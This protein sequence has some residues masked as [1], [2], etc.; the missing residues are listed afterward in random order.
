M[1]DISAL[2]ANAAQTN[3]DFDLGK[4]NKSYWE[5][6]DQAAK[7]N[8]RDTLRNMPVG[9]NGELDYPAM[10][11][12]LV[13]GGDVANGVGFANLAA[14]QQE[15]RDYFNS[16]PPSTARGAITPDIAPR[17]QPGGE[18]NPQGGGRGPVATGP[19]SIAGIVGGLTP[20]PDLQGKIITQVASQARLDPNAAIDD[21]ATL[22]RITQVSQAAV[23][24]F[25]GQQPPQPQVAQPQP[26]VA[27]AQPQPQSEP[28]PLPPM[29]QMSPEDQQAAKR[30]AYFSGSPDKAVAETARVKLKAILDKYAPTNE[31]KNARASGETVPVYQQRAVDQAI[32][33]AGGVERAKQEVAEQGEYKTE[34]KAASNKLQVLNTMRAIIDADKN[35]DLGF[36]ADTSLK[37]QKV[38]QRLGITSLFGKN[39]TDLS[40]PELLQKLGT[41]LASESTKAISAR[42]AVFEFSTFLKNNPGLLLTREGNLRLIDLLSQQAKRQVDLG[43]LI[44]DNQDKWSKWDNVVEKYD[45]DHPIIDPTTKKVLSTDSIIAPGPPQA[46]APPANRTASQAPFSS[47]RFNSTAEARAAGAQSGDIVLDQDGTARR[48]K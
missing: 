37:I 38:A 11:R 32:E 26:Q 2:L 13:Q 4:I 33:Q 8:L 19:N 14:N 46:P 25:G 12:A 15:R 41:Q 5:G 27:Q 29:E 17:I 44:P 30:E 42:P 21:P 47:Q 34:G 43:R 24:R 45:R 23:G 18:S 10:V 6:Q 20:D 31:E 39:V 48:L 1:A 28:V 7:N 40:G 36:A 22:Q 35:M 9:K 3:A 16:L